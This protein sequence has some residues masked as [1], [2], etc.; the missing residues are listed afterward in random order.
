MQRRLRETVQKPELFFGLVAPVGSDLSRVTEDLARALAGVVYRSHTIHLIELIHELEKW[1]E[2]PEDPLDV[3]IGKHMDAGNEL[4]RVMGTGD[5]IA[6][7]GIGAVQTLRSSG[8][9]VPAPNYAYI[10]RSLKHPERSQNTAENLWWRFLSDRCVLAKK[11]PSGAS[12]SGNCGILSS[13]SV[14]GF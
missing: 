11:Q 5:A 12:R 4:R 6:T 2:V 1:K 13:V 7:L 3:R 8:F 14:S 10:F 9:E